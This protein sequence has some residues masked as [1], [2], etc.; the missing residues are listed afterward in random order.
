MVTLDE[1]KGDGPAEPPAG[2]HKC[3]CG[4]VVKSDEWCSQCKA[5]LDH[6]RCIDGG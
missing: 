5:C 1:L 4:K 6:C 2:T 3:A